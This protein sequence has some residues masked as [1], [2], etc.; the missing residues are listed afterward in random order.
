MDTKQTEKYTCECGSTLLLHGK[1][2]HNKTLKHKNFLSL[3]IKNISVNKEK[4]I[5]LSEK[6]IKQKNF[7]ERQREILGD[8]EYK[9][10]ES[11]KRRQRR[12]KQKLREQPPKVEVEVEEEKEEINLTQSNREFT[13]NLPTKSLINRKNKNIDPSTNAQYMKRLSFLYK[14]LTGKKDFKADNLEWLRDANEITKFIN[15][16][17]AS[18][19]TKNAYINAITSILARVPSFEEEHKIYSSLNSKLIKKTQSEKEKNVLSDKELKNI[20]PWK[21]ILKLGSHIKDPRDKLIYSMYT[22]IPPRRLDDYRLM[23]IVRN[24]NQKFVDNLPKNY[25]YIYL[26]KKDMP[27][28]MVINRYKTASTYGSYKASV[29]TKLGKIIQNYVKK[30]QLKNCEFLFS[31]EENCKVYTPGA[32]SAVVTDVFKKVTGRNLGVDLLRISFI[33]FIYSQRIS[34]AEKNKI[35]I[36]MAHSRETAENIYNKINL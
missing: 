32:F 5:K 20:L 19:S 11:E 9:R 28:Y 16:R 33:S 6:A 23:K 15:N 8:E 27:K 29:P 17:W 2:R 22:E 34:V 25:N 14:S 31:Q 24:R 3:K 26:D 7:R 12:A 10:I 30:Y 1:I 13:E 36:A 18:T 21:K 35:A 4:M